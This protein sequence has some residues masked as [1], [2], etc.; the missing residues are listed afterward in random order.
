MDADSSPSR[1][2]SSP[3]K[4]GSVEPAN[5]A[6]VAKDRFQTPN[7]V[8]SERY[9]LRDPFAEVTYRSHSMVNM[10]AKA[11]Q[12][13][14]HRFV[15]LDAEGRRTTVQRL[16]GRWQRGPQR[17]AAPER[18]IDP[19]P[20]RDEVPDV[21]G[22]E[23]SPPK[24][25]WQ[26]PL[27]PA[28]A[29]SPVNEPA[30]Q[31]VDDQ[32]LARVDAEAD[33]AARVA[34]LEAALLER[35]LIKR[36]PVTIGDVTVGRT[37][38]RFRG[39]TSRVAFTESTFRLATDT[40]SP[41]VARSMV[42][43]AEARNWQGL[44]VSGNEEF[45]RLVWLEA[46]VRGVKAL[47][48]EATPA[49]LELLKKERESRLVNRIEPTRQVPGDKADPA[50]PAEKGS[51][52][53]SGGRKAVLVAIEA[54]LVAKSVPE[55]QREAIMAAATEKLAQRTRDGQAPRVKVYDKAAPS[56]RPVL[57]PVPEV[58]RTRERAGPTR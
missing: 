46:S 58:Q 30:P 17:P 51:A 49:D 56:Q 48:Y 25:P 10:I 35:Y 36:A 57:A 41:S 27:H 39:D 7:D 13:G 14:I 32:A 18:P 54:V 40:N 22:N 52:R 42:D 50:A 8:P 55:K 16:D 31:K 44:R 15:A 19:A 38:Y 23:S 47:G 53:G 29:R 1:T 2:P 12:L 11:D 28:A 3:A 20:G 4:G 5:R 26:A 33:R 9:E 24:V 45:R 43:V 37:E 34:R 6:E 21:S